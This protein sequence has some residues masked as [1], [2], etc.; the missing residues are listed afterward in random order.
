ME[1]TWSEAQR[2]KTPKGAPMPMQQ[3]RAYGAACKR[4]GSQVM[5]LEGRAGGKPVASA[6][7]LRRTWPLFGQF[8]LLSRGPLFAPSVG[9]A[10]AGRAT[11]DLVAMLAP[12]H[13]G[14]MATPDCIDGRDPLMGQGLLQMVT[15][16]HVARLSLKE[17]EAALRAALHQKWRNRLKR[18]E[19]AGLFLDSGPMPPDPGHW[20]LREEARQA[21]QRR[22]ARLP[23]EFAV[24]W[25]SLGESLLVTA[26]DKSGPVAGMLFLIHAPW[27]SYH[28]GWT[29]EDGRRMDA[30]NLLMWTG[31]LALKARGLTALELGTLDT[32]KTPGLARFKLGT[33]A[34]PVPLGATWMR[35][36]GSGAVARLA[37]LRRAA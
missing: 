27:A 13:R 23:P 30:H 2:P 29:S 3:H 7:I 32:V 26:S 33:G 11:R 24:A 14:V 36:V 12:D 16:G 15:G 20:L 28:L 31:M 1:I 37:G 8:A 5:W 17:P 10:D 4:I 25:A 19:G 35:S 18:A 6:Q 21:S 22:Y 34:V 9:A